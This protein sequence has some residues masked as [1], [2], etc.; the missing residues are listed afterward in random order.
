MPDLLPRHEPMGHQG[1]GP[2]FGTQTACANSRDVPSQPQ[3]DG[4]RGG[5]GIARSWGARGGWVLGPAYRT[6]H[7]VLRV[8]MLGRDARTHDGRPE[9]DYNLKDASTG[10]RDRDDGPWN[11][12]M[13]GESAGLWMKWEVYASEN[14]NRQGW[15]VFDVRRR[16]R[17]DSAAGSGQLPK[18]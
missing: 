15:G 7:C 18:R 17:K 6:P 9:L 5:A 8:W 16:V 10:W 11:R 12:S 3:T 13:G 1:W 14:A 2:P 4:A